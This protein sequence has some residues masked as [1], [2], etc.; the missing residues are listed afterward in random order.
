MIKLTAILNEI[1]VTTYPF[2]KILEA[3]IEWAKVEYDPNLSSDYEEPFDYLNSIGTNFS[4]R[5][6]KMLALSIKQID[7]TLMNMMGE[8]IGAY[9]TE[10]LRHTIQKICEKLNTPPK[11]TK[12]LINELDKLYNYNEKI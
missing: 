3:Y 7:D 2:N 6:I 9:Y 10:Y 12:D 11:I 1:T 4:T 8:P 5:N